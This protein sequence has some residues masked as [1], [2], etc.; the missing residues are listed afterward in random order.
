[1]APGD[2]SFRASAADRDAGLC[3]WWQ[4]SQGKPVEW[5]AETTCGKL[6]GLAALASWQRT[7]STAV[8]SFAGVTEPGS[9]ACF[10]SG[11]W[12]ASQFTCACLPSF[13]LLEHVGMAGFAG[14]MAGEI[15]RPGRDFGKRVAAVVSV[16]P[17]AFRH[18]EASDD[19]E[20]KHAGNETLLPIGKDV[21][22]LE[23]HS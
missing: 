4:V 9:S 21:P 20:Q 2:G 3:G 14:L 1:M 17:K 18:Q 6:L 19:Q 10:A 8:S 5:S 16:L 13:L 22:H 7:Q 15:D 11:P 12:Q 23:K